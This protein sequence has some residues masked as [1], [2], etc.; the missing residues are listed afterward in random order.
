[1]VYDSLLFSRR[2]CNGLD[3][4]SP[5]IK[6]TIKQNIILDSIARFAIAVIGQN[7]AFT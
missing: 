7:T 6:A 4:I 5:I 2:G 3:S 1:M